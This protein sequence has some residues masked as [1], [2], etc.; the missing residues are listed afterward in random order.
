[1][2]NRFQAWSVFYVAVA[3]GS[4]AAC[5]APAPQPSRPGA[6]TGADQNV[7]PGDPVAAS[8]ALA[9]EKAHEREAKTAAKASEKKVAAG[10][11]TIDCAVKLPDDPTD[12]PELCRSFQ[13]EVVDETGAE[14]TRFRF[15]P[16]AR[17]RFTA[18]VG[19]KYRIRP[20]IGKN[21]AFSIEP[22]R[23]LTVGERA[24][25]QLRQKE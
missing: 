18:K 7:G 8:V 24:R 9:A 15:G 23:D 1:M 16:D 3:V 20:V 22:D 10:T 2:R 5:A 14:T 17:Y 6:P 21:W 25:V 11:I 12:N 13:M 19:K 4:L